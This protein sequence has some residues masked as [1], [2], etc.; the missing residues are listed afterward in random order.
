MAIKLDTKSYGYSASTNALTWSHTNSGNLIIVVIGVSQAR[1]VSGV[2]YG[3][4]ALTLATS[5][6]NGNSKAYIYYKFNPKTGSNNVVVSYSTTADSIA[7]VAT[8]F[9][10]AGVLGTTNTKT[11][12]AQNKSIDITPTY[13]NSLIITC[14]GCVSGDNNPSGTGQIEIFTGAN[15]TGDYDILSGQTGIN[16][17]QSWTSDASNDYAL[18]AAEF[19]SI[20]LSNFFNFF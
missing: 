3:G 10:S 14:V 8:F 7:G 20:N 11:G 9:N 4:D 12:T 15:R 2:T 5:T 16:Q 18:V 17:T 6:V 19:K 1:T 13:Y